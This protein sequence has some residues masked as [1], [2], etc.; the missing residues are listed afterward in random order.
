MSD[1]EEDDTVPLLRAKP[2]RLNY[3][4]RYDQVS[5]HSADTDFEPDPSADE[6]RKKKPKAVYSKRKKQKIAA[7]VAVVVIFLSVMIGLIYVYV[8]QSDEFVEISCGKVSGNKE[9]LTVE[10]V[11]YT[12]LTLPTILLV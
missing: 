2:V 1:K 5:W 7:L 4:K 12:H 10:A 9:T 8:K 11:S 3:T 6:R